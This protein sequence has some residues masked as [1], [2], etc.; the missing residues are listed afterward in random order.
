MRDVLDEVANDVLCFGIGAEP[1]ADG[2]DSLA[3]KNL[4][5]AT[6]GEIETS[7]RTV[8]GRGER[9]RHVFGMSGGNDGLNDIGGSDS[10]KACAT[11][12]RSVPCK[13]RCAGFTGRAT[14]DEN[15]A[16]A[17]FV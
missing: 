15:V 4:F 2:E 11:A 1:R 17:A 9:L 3:R 12:K 10:G 5:Q 6:R 14:D 8:T 13:N 16:E 7:N